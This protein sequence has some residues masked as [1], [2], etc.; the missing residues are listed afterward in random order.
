M[1]RNEI[2]GI[3][4]MAVRMAEIGKI[5]IGGKGEK[6]TSKHGNEFRLPEKYDH[7][8]ITTTEKDSEG[9]F[10]KDKEV[11]E[12]L[13]EKPRELDIVLLYDEV[14]LNFPHFYALYSGRTLKCKGN[15]ETAVRYLKDGG[16]KD[17]S[18]NPDTCEYYQKDKC[19]VNGIFNC[20]LKQTQKVG[21]VY[22]FRTTS[23]NSVNNI[24]GSLHF[25]KSLTGGVLAGIP[26]K[27]VL[28]PKTTTVENNGSRFQTT[29][30]V[31]HIEYDGNVNELQ[32][33]AFRIAK[34]RTQNEY[35]LE[36]VEEFA[37]NNMITGETDDEAEDVNEE[38]YPNQI[39]DVVEIE[40]D[41]DKAEKDEP[42]E[43][44]QEQNQ[45]Q[46]TQ[47]TKHE[48]KEQEEEANDVKDQ[49]GE[50][51]SENNSEDSEKDN[52]KEEKDQE[53]FNLF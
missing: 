18:C 26:L 37:K 33:T 8:V 53:Q 41:E 15:G 6:R 52:E 42:V 51:D 50:K 43:V 11:M 20:V 12:L 34:E 25:I 45:K 2:N 16:E 4:D 19:K 48:E 49:P 30:Y 47:E 35:K 23:W 17:V 29:V 31:V 10:K 36:K 32:E 22:R 24:L 46:D 14:N 9:N 5:K 28:K 21:G 27:M 44:E 13:G 7:F 1:K 39:E 38:F 3:K 40:E